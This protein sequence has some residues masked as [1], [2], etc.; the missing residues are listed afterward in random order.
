M[1]V[2]VLLL[3]WRLVVSPILLGPEPGSGSGG[4]STCSAQGMKAYWVQPGD[5]C[6][7]I[8]KTHGCSLDQLKDANKALDCKLLMP[9]TTICL[10]GPAGEGKAPT[11]GGKR[12][13]SQ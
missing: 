3:V 1:V 13:K 10:P 9:G 6:W 12:K 5:T 8:A 2:V 7:E 4:S 11:G